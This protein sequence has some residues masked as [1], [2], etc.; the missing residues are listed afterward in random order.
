MAWP[1]GTIWNVGSCLAY[2]KIY[3]FGGHNGGNQ[4]TIMEYD[5][6]AGTLTQVASMLVTGNGVRATLGTDGWIYYWRSWDGSA[7]WN[8]IERFHPVTKAVEMRTAVLPYTDNLGAQHVFHV[9]SESA[10]YFF[11][12]G[13]DP[14]LHKYA[15]LTDTLTDTGLAVPGQFS[16]YVATQDTSD[17]RTIYVLGQ[18]ATTSDPLQLLKVSLSGTA[19]KSSVTITATDANASEAGL[20]AGQFTVTRTGSTASGLAV[21]YTV[22]G[23]ATSG[24]DY[25]AL[26]GTLTIPAGALTATI[27]VTPLND[28]AVEGPEKLEAVLDGVAAVESRVDL[29]LAARR[30]PVRVARAQAGLLD[31]DGPHAPPAAEQRAQPFHAGEEA[32]AVLLHHRQQEVAAGVPGQARV[33]QRRQPRQQQPARLALV[34]RERQRALQHVA[35]RQHAE[36]VAQLPRAAAAVE[37]GDDG[38][39]V[40]P[41][42]LLQP[43]EHARQ[44]GAPAEA[45]HLHHPQVHGGIL[46]RLR[47]QCG[48]ARLAWTAAPGA[49][50]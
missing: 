36:F 33:F 22:A 10:L 50:S 1:I 20:D 2:G 29:D 38:V 26:P 4:T 6:G 17:E 19:A 31:A 13:L 8:A 46:P 42:V 27:G 44:A 34:A 48:H 45:A 5:P 3:Y 28:S 25:Q 30:R 11:R 37:H 35:R 14:K 24:S 7:S 15:Y 32:A 16:P 39:H 18:G 9:A 41:G 49:I 43:A 47:V 23:T 21:D 12:S 40:E